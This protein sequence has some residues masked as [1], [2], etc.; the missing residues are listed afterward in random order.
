MFQN[1]KGDQTFETTAELIFPASRF[2]NGIEIRCEADN[3][4]MLEAGEAPL[5]SSFTLDVLCMFFI[6]NDTMLW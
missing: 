6:D 3:S 2:D 1:K 4:V 5:H